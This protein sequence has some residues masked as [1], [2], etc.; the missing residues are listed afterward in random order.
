MLFGLFKKKKKSAGQGPALVDMDQ[1]PLEPGDRVE[2]FRY[3]LGVS[4]IIEEDGKY[5]Y[6]SERDGRRI[7]WVKMIDASTKTQ[8]V[9]KLQAD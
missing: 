4:V 5:Y 7:I 1:T 3:D 9:R 6:E 2:V 8:K